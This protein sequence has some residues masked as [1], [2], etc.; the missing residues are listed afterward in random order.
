MKGGIKLSNGHVLRYVVA[1]GALGFDGKGWP[2][3][4]PLVKLGLIKPEFFTV[5]IKTLTRYPREGNLRLWKPWECVRLIPGGSV[6]KVGLTNRGIRWWCNMVAPRIDFKKTPLIGS[7]YGEGKELV[8]M[9]EMLNSVD[10]VGLEVNPSCPNTGHMDTAEIVI[11]DV[12]AVKHASCHPIIIK[13]SIA[14]DYPA[15][16]KG[17]KGVAEAI[18][19]NSV[20]WEIAFPGRRSPLWK[21]EKKV[22]G[23]GGG[24]SGKPAQKFNW[25]AVGK[26]VQQGDLP[27]ICPSIME[28]KDIDYARERLGASAVSFGTI[29]FRT[30]W[31]PT[32]FVERDMKREES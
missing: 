23:G 15:I 1:S 17:L 12:K 4:W 30:P 6:N 19:L 28:F 5:V 29:H 7:I 13:A 2:W 31:A 10:L 8:E 3:E 25:P 22:G 14:Q 18:T 27:V 26:L 16:A 9:A 24:V 32:K 20:P 11:N 21:L